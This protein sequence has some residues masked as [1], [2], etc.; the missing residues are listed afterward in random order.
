MT[1][2]YHLIDISSS[3]VRCQRCRY[4]GGSSL[5]AGDGRSCLVATRHLIHHNFDFKTFSCTLNISVNGS[6]HLDTNHIRFVTTFIVQSVVVF[7][8][9]LRFTTFLL[10]STILLTVKN[11]NRLLFA[12]FIY[13]GVLLRRLLY[14]LEGKTVDVTDPLIHTS[15]IVVEVIFGEF[16]LSL[17]G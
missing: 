16:I 17:V 10:I 13:Q 3:S 9:L 12:V 1:E 5:R 4:S 2:W 15:Q 14:Q 8:S 11:K 6:E 7:T